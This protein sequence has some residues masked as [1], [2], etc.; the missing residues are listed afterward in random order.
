MTRILL[1]VETSPDDGEPVAIMHHARRLKVRE[2]IDRWD[3]TAHAYVKLIA[4]D[5]NLYVIRHDIGENEWEMVLM[6]GIVGKG[7]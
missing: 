3:G 7:S 4:D 2:I 1:H 6:E 5:G